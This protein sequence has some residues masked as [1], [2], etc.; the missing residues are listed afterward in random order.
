M[1]V[2]PCLSCGACCA[3][4][5][6]VLHW[7]ETDPSLELHTPAEL[8]EPLDP[9]RVVMRGTY[10]APVRCQA[11]RGVV[12]RDA[13]CGI[14]AQRPSPCRDLQPAWLH[15]EASPQCDRARQAHGLAPLDP[16]SW[17]AA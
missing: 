14:Y 12:G 1:A 16:S 5:R 10:S 11:L 17:R 3:A 2:H 15:G 8:T 13:H 7:S 9:H 6:V 4:Y